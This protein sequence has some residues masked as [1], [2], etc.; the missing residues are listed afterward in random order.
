VLETV[1]LDIFEL[2]RICPFFPLSSPQ[3]KMRSAAAVAK[4]DYLMA[5]IPPQIQKWMEEAEEEKKWAQEN[6]QQ[7]QQQEE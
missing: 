4:M 7:Q 5:N 6:Q 1:D 3:L 2:T